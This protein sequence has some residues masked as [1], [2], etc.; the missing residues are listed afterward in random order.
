MNFF[1][2]LKYASA[3]FWHKIFN[4]C[5]ALHISNNFDFACE[6]QQIQIQTTLK[7]PTQSLWSSS[8]KEYHSEVT[9]LWKRL[10]IMAWSNYSHKHI[11][12]A[13]K[14]TAGSAGP[15]RVRAG[16]TLMNAQATVIF[17]HMISKCSAITLQKQKSFCKSKCSSWKH[18][19][20][21]QEQLL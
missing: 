5:S 15:P 18:D 2:I 12:N 7:C 8:D 21:L 3:D 20:T 19:V 1:Y 13:S 4:Y 10:R 14:Q 16:D 9:S 6:P 17:H 11:I